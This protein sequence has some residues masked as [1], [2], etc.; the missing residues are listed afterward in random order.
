MQCQNASATKLKK[1]QNTT[2]TKY[3]CNKSQM[4]QNTI[5]TKCKCDKIQK[6]TA[7]RNIT[8]FTIANYIM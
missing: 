1:G 6:A 7:N 8:W 4:G 5:V 3:K 2:D